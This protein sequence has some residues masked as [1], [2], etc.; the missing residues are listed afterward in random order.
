MLISA[1]KKIAGSS[2]SKRFSPRHQRLPTR[3]RGFARMVLKWAKAD[4]DCG[5]TLKVPRSIGL[6]LPAVAVHQWKK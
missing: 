1:G 4:G 3:R 5:M 2:C 6:E